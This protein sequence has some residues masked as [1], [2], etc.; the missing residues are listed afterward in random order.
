M[1]VRLPEE[2]LA[3]Y[4]PDRLASE[5]ELASAYEAD[6]QVKKA[7]RLLEHVVSMERSKFSELHP[8]RVVSE[9]MLAA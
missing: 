1:L 8:S 2:V 5:H 6:G 7:I 4:H 9:Q 3:E